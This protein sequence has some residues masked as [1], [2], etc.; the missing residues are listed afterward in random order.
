M[1]ARLICESEE[2][3]ED[4]GTRD[5]RPTK[6]LKHDMSFVVAFPLD[7]WDLRDLGI[8]LVRVGPAHPRKK[9]KLAVDGENPR[10]CWDGPKYLDQGQTYQA[11]VATLVEATVRRHHLAKLTTTFV[12][13]IDGHNCA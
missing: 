1:P 5:E 2:S 8:I 9:S 4:E 3:K 10:R 6:K 13:M 7:A 12:E 11:D